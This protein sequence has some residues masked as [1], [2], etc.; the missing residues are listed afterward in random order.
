MRVQ[1]AGI[2][3]EDP[4]NVKDCLLM[5]F[6]VVAALAIRLYF[7]QFYRVISAD[8]I[9]YVGIAED[10]ITG[11]GLAKATH[12]PPFYPILV[13]IASRVF[14]DFELAGRVVS[15]V[16]GSLI[17][18]PVYLLGKEFYR[19]K[20]GLIAAILTMSWWSIRNWSGEVMS[21]ATYMTLLLLGVYLVW[22]AV[23]R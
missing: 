17:V 14:K 5:V 23:E 18:I 20:T 7:H 2:S 11:K 13:G 16:M 22:I 6:L 9:A 8:G 1:S 12:Y 10:F 4:L 3:S 15:M 19:R 21:Q